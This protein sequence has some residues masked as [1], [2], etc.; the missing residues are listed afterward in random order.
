MRSFFY[1]LCRCVLR[2]ASPVTFAV[3]AV[4]VSHG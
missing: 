2:G 4:E 1:H 3:R